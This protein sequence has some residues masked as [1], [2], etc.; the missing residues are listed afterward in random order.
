MIDKLLTDAASANLCELMGLDAAQQARYKAF[1]GL[2]EADLALLVELA[3]VIERHA[4]AVVDGFYV[5]VQHYP[6]LEQ[7]I[8]GVGSNMER[9]KR[10]QRAYLLELFKGDVGPDYF[11][12]RLR[13]GVIHHKIGLT[14]RWYLG[15]Y[16]VYMQLLAPII[17][18]H[19]R[20][21]HGRALQ[22]VLALNK[23]LSLDAQLAIDTYIHSLTAE[24]NVVSLSKE[25]LEQRLAAYNGLIDRVTQ[26]DLTA[27]VEAT[28]DDDLARL[29]GNLNKMTDRLAEMTS[30][31]AE[32]S[33][34]MLVSVEQ[35]RA[36]I[37]AQSS[38]A[39]Q[40]AASVNETTATLEQIKATSQQTLEKA[41]ALKEVADRARSEGDQ[42]LTAVE[43]AV[44]AMRHTRGQV[45]AIA[46]HIG[47]LNERLQQ[48]GDITNAVGELAS[49][50]KM[51]AL[52]ASIE[53]A[54]AGDAGRGFAVVAEE[55]RDLA[56][57]SRQATT[58]VQ[59][60]L[61]E[62]RNAA[63][64]AVRA[65]EEG[66]EGA[67]RG[68][69]L[70]DRAG[71]TLHSLNRVIHDTAMASQQ[72]VAAVRQEAAGIDQ[73]RIAMGDISQVTS[74]FV[75][76][77][78]QTEAATDQLTDYAALLQN[79]VKLF[80]VGGARFDFDRAR[81]LHHTWV[82]RLEAFLAGRE[83]LAEEEAVSHHHCQLGRWYDGE[84]LQRYGHIP[85]MLAL[86]APHRE[87]HELIHD[88]VQ[89]QNHGRHPNAA[90]VMAR[91]R[92]LSARIIELLD[93]IEAKSRALDS[94][95]GRT[96]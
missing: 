62:I 93:V 3:P 50:S 63:A 12:R 46:G 47:V 89:Q 48:I 95:R 75:A 85:E 43:A 17:F 14:P 30:E 91:V 20:W 34:A 36:S 7:L 38:G 39:A 70:A 19:W 29:G 11:E 1:I 64:R 41:S 84:G 74:Q 42:G 96:E 61:V 76:A 90:Q 67:D 18:K 94:N 8:H 6:E 49:Q 71:E 31:V 80:Q 13:V 88:V 16:S 58:Q 83:T 55:V 21:Q 77:T 9:L 33:N 56:E 25:E 81:T 22:A 82:A 68:A 28:G 5:N 66:N 86:D 27:H 73:I 40:Q 52:N 23:M 4:D 60:I 65:V 59:G 35:V 87:L 2:T 72:I 44:N 79:M 15:S 10:T 26:G 37:T 54:K 53:A 24:L 92:A 57:Q 51:L 32:S 78:H 69:N 45:E